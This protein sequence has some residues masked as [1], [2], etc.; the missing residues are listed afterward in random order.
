M[1]P[2]SDYLLVLSTCPNVAVAED[3]ATELLNKRLVACVNMIPGV[4]SMYHWQGAVQKDQEVVLL[5]KTQHDDYDALQD[6]LRRVHPYELPEIIAVSL[7]NALPAYLSWI[8]D[9]VTK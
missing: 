8:S 9:S 7:E 2:A 6:A 1:R 3:I 5:M 4:I